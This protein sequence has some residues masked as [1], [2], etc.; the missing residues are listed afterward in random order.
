LIENN[1]KLQLDDKAWKRL[2]IDTKYFDE[3]FKWKLIVALTEKLPEDRGIDDILDGILIKSENWQA[4]NLLMNKYRGKVQT[5]YIDPPFNT[6]EEFLYKDNYQNSTW[7]TLMENRLSLSKHLLKD[8]GSLYCHLDHNS[9]YLV[10]FLLDSIFGHD[11][12][13]NEIVWKRLTYKQ[14]QT[15]G[16]GVLHDTILYYTKTDNY[17]WTDY[18][19]DYEQETINKYFYWVETPD[20]RNIKLSK[21]QLDGKEPIPEG[22][23][24]ALNPLINVNPDRPNLRYE[25]LGFVRTWKYTKEKMI[26]L[27]KKGI[28]FQPKPEALPQKKQYL[29]ESKGMKLNDLWTDISGVMGNSKECLGFNTQ[30]PEALLER[31]ILA[32]SNENDWVL[33]F[34]LGSGTTTAVT[35]KLKRKWI[36]IEMGDYFDYIVL[37]RMKEVLAGSGK[38]EPCGISRKVNWQGGGIFKYHT[39]EQ[40]EDALENIEFENSQKEL[41]GLT[42]YLVKYFLEWE[43]KRSRTFLNID[44]LK[45]PFNYKLKII[46]NYQQK[47]VSADL[48][49]T[50]NYLLGLHVK[51]YKVLEDNNREY[52]FVFG[53]KSGKKIAVIWRCLKDINFE[54]DKEIIEEQIMEFNPDDIYI[55]GDSM[56]KGFKPI[57]PVFRS[58][59]FRRRNNARL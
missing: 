7:L 50:F 4:L 15:K 22:R 30:K 5:I 44:E 43:T 18:R 2:P 28:V 36:G 52:I 47:I 13:Q 54:K 41:Y 17:L 6:G 35:H 51:G 23:R 8:T 11:N 1:G 48:I 31:I 34:F 46:E 20:G 59:M 49:E 25:F 19:V 55:N 26:E 37:S 10:R 27:Y 45:D 24:F 14:T 9:N 58:L 16:Y 53:K 39:L 29:D 32:S 38:H 42:D 57:E 56:V 40:Y 3:E 12:F 33:D 21:A